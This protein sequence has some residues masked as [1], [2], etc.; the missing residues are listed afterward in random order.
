MVLVPLVGVMLVRYGTADA[1]ATTA[2]LSTST[3]ATIN[4]A[5]RLRFFI[6]T[7]LIDS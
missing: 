1:P 2:R 4:T 5:P 6:I 3:T 7:L